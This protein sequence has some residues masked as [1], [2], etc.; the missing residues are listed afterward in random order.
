[1]FI[2]VNDSSVYIKLPNDPNNG[3]PFY[4]SARLASTGSYYGSKVTLTGDFNGDRYADLVAINDTNQQV[5]LFTPGS[6]SFG[7]TA[8]WGAGAFYGSR[9]TVT[10]DVNGDYLDDLVAVNDTT[11]YVRISNGSSFGPPTLWSQ[12]AFYGDQTTVAGDVNLDGR[13]DLVAVN[14]NS[15][16]VEL[17][18]GHNFGPSTWWST[19]STI[20]PARAFLLTSPLDTV[21]KGWL[22]SVQD[23]AIKAL[24]SDG[25]KFNPPVQLSSDAFYGGIGTFFGQALISL[26]E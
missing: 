15:V 12:G 25:T 6:V 23:S 4:L 14:S 19:V 11:V 13:A 9:A 24:T 8:T 5:K 1:M 2:A 18:S 10:A 22:L 26:P 7:T 17:S 16:Y 21:N 20:A 3:P